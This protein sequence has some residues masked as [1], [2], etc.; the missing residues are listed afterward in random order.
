M[1]RG[2]AGAA[3]VGLAIAIAG[4]RG[5]GT[6]GAPGDGAPSASTAT[7]TSTSTALGTSTSSAGT[8]ASTSAGTGP[9]NPLASAPCRII[10][11]SGHA[12]GDAGAMVLQGDV[13]GGWIT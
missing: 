1:V 11:L 13:P 8:P 7:G 10:G 4:C 9:R 6:E 12:A 5:R 2:P 3:I